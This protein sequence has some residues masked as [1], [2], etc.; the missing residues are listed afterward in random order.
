M[1]AIGLTPDDIEEEEVEVWPDAW[2]AFCLF[3]ALGTQWR[4]GQGG[5]S[6]L[7]YTAIPTTA[8]MLGI[9]RRDLDD[10][11]PDLRI[12]EHEALAVM[13]EAAE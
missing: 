9:K 10:I 8:S 5:P 11:F 7:D 12:M 13:A 1:A 3:E 2:P 6:G 4:L